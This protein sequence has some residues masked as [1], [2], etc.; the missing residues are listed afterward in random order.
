MPRPST[1][2]LLSPELRTRFY[3]LLKDP[4]VTQQQVADEINAALG[5]R[6]LSKS[7]V[8]R[9]AVSM[10]RFAERNAQ[11]REL[12]REY[13]NV[14]GQ[15]GQQEF[16]EVIVHQLRDVIYDL[17]LEIQELQQSP[18]AEDPDAHAERVTKIAELI[19]RASRSVRETET[20]ADRSAERRRKLREEV[21]AAAAEAA[22]TEAR[23]A[24]I[25]DDTVAAIKRRILGVAA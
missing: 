15:E 5:E 7:A 14:V 9:R 18:P 25:S 12:A 8:N 22:T 6:R 10:R 3:E 1:V 20:A 23:A 17:M 11:A 24:G 19:T 4:N 2:D 16:S 13:L 21:A